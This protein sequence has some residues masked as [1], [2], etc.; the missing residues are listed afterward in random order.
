M[1]ADCAAVVLA[2]GAGTRMGGDLPKPLHPVAGR[3]MVLRVLDALAGVEADP[4]VIVVGHGAA[5]VSDAVR[6]GAPRPER[7]VF[8]TQH[9]QRGTGDAA[10]VGLAALTQQ[11]QHS[12]IDDVLV[13]PGDA[14]LLRPETLRQ[15]V[16]QRRRCDAAASVLTAQLADPAGYGRIV[17]T[18]GPI[19]IVEQRDASPS[20]R[21]IREVNA[22]VY[23]FGLEPLRRA[24]RALSPANAQAE[25]YLTEAIGMLAHRGEKIA[26]VAAADPAE[27]LGANDADQLAACEAALAARTVLTCRHRQSPSELRLV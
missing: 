4:V 27:A 11:R 10:R 16:T 8:A 17:R 13:L 18:D 19:R 26:A 12:Q 20:Q 3:A 1:T 23:C 9:A 2:A 24:L 5:Q 25:H 7:L 14:P 15:V 22:G 21:R 6:A